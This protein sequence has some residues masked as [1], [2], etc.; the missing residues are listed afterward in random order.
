MK[1]D[2]MGKVALATLADN[3]KSL[4]KAV[5]SDS[6]PCDLLAYCILLFAFY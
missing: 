5:M 4:S 1:T 3:D 2:P 6:M